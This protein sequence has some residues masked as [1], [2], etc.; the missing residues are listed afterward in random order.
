MFAVL[1]IV[2]VMLVVLAAIPSVAHALE[3]PAKLH[4]DR[5]TYYAVQPIYYPGFTF[6]GFAE[7]AAILA[8]ALLL[9]FTP[10]GTFH[11][12]L[13]LI[14]LAGMVVMHAIYWLLIHPVNKFWLADVT[15]KGSGAAFFATASKREGW[16]PDWTELR[17]RWEYSHL[18]RAIITS[19]SLLALVI[20]LA[21]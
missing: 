9:W 12:W 20:A 15:L 16:N 3:L 11:F 14:A 8:T 10:A 2:T 17:D 13:V 6:A 19:V 21:V 7:P 18:A 1:Q 5:Q 4:L